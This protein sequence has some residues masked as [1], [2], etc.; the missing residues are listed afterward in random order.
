VAVRVRMGLHTGAPQ[1]TADGYVSLDVHRATLCFQNRCCT[2]FWLLTNPLELGY[3]T[4]SYGSTGRQVMGIVTVCDWKHKNG[5]TDTVCFQFVIWVIRDPVALSAY[6]AQ[7]SYELA[8]FWLTQRASVGE[9][10]HYTPQTGRDTVPR[11][12]SRLHEE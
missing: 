9:T 6:L 3:P 10:A 8:H 12:L 5:R 4:T 11:G 1:R 2:P 7:L